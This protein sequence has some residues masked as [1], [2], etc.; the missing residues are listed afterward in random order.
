MRVVFLSIHFIFDCYLFF[1][2]FD[3]SFFWEID[4]KLGCRLS[5][6][7][8]NDVSAFSV[9][10]LIFDQDENLEANILSANQCFENPGNRNPW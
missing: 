5:I 6:F 4:A 3:E 9:F 7:S 1:N 8:K 2:G 10:L